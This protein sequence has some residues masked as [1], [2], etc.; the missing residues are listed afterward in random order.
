MAAKCVGKAT[1]LL[2]AMPLMPRFV[3]SV[4][5]GGG[6]SEVGWRILPPVSTPGVAGSPGVISSLAGIFLVGCKSLSNT[7]QCWR[8]RCYLH[9]LVRAYSRPPVTA[10][11]SRTSRWYRG[12]RGPC[13]VSTTAGWCD[14]SHSELFQIEA[15]H[16][17]GGAARGFTE[18]T[19]MDGDRAGA[20]RL[21]GGG[22]GEGRAIDDEHVHVVVGET[23]FQ[24]WDL[25][26]RALGDRR[27]YAPPGA[28]SARGGP[29]TSASRAP[30][31]RCPRSPAGRLS[32]QRCLP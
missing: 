29:T 28:T 14:G 11:P 17:V 18:R 32:Q 10:A 26:P 21:D 20:E 3:C 1:V 4:S 15:L 27:L 12:R 7:W 9:L 31:A 8:W 5:R 30:R 24:L 6:S 2:V 25:D 22:D 13:A 16:D 19:I 23:T